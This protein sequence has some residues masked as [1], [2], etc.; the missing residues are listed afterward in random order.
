[1]RAR[2]R[3]FYQRARPCA[4]FENENETRGKKR[5]KDNKDSP[6]CP[7]PPFGHA[8]SIVGARAVGGAA[9]AHASYR[10][11]ARTR[12]MSPDGSDT[13]V[14]SGLGLGK[15]SEEKNTGFSTS[16]RRRRRRRAEE[17]IDKR[18]KKKNL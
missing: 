12:L 15:K 18:Q 9:A 4:V 10:S 2:R 8:L 11:R 6:P 7:R 13:S 16:S 1:M 17:L 14:V 5:E 3:G